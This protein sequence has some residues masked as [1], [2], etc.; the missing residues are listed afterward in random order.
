MLFG[1]VIQLTL[2]IWLSTKVVF[3]ITMSLVGL[4]IFRSLVVIME[5]YASNPYVRNVC[6]G[7]TMAM[8]PRRATGRFEDPPAADPVVVFH[9][10]VRFNH[11]LGLLCPGGPQITRHF[12]QCLDE[13]QEQ[14]EDY[15]LLGLSRW[16]SGDRGSQNTMMYVFYFRDLEGLAR[17]SQSDIHRDAWAWASRTNPKYIG[18]F[19]ETFSVPRH[20]YETVYVNMPRTL[21]GDAMVCCEVDDADGQEEDR[22]WVRT[23]VD[24]GNSRLQTMWGRMGRVQR[25]RRRE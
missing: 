17:F 6:R 15:G 3:M 5:G 1:A 19:H 14:A 11:P 22:E 7:R 12:F 4:T 8:L 9:F 10:G 18:F 21:L 13:I 2:L 20:A 23:L 25:R 16:Q 24:A